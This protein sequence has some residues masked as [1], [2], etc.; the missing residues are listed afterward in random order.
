[1]PRKPSKKPSK[2]REFMTTDD[3]IDDEDI[4]HGTPD[5]DGNVFLRRSAA[6]KPKDGKRG[7]GKKPS[8]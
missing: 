1:M 4:V 5:I 3:I 6:K 8:G 7:K 2:P